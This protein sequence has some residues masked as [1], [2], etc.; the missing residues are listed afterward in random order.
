VKNT[1]VREKERRKKEKKRGGKKSENEEET[2]E[3][4]RIGVNVKWEERRE[5]WRKKEKAMSIEIQRICP[6][7]IK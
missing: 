4:I 6:F 5:E 1:E 2:K 3:C 7:M